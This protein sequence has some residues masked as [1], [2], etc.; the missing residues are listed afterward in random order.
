VRLA[1]SVRAAIF[2]TAAAFLIFYQDHS[3]EV[4]M[5]V[6]LFVTAALAISGVVTNRASAKQY[7]VPTALSVVVA[8]LTLVFL[9]VENDKLFS[10]RALV[11]VFAI[12]M[13]VYEF[14]LSRKA[15]PDDVLEL[16]IAAGIGL[17]TGLV[18]SLA[19]LDVGNAVGFLSAYLAISATQ[20]AVWAASPTNGKKTRNG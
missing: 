19:P 13:A 12:G 9:L 2:G 18:F 10:F 20:R 6:L 17:L 11:F 5:M 14:V 8:L 15:N 7:L 1:N 16:R 4:G 3:V